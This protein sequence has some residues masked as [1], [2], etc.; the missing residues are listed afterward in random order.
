MNSNLKECICDKT[1]HIN[2]YIFYF[3]YPQEKGYESWYWHDFDLKLVQYLYKKFPLSAIGHL[4]QDASF[5]RLFNKASLSSMIEIP[6]KKFFITRLNDE[7]KDKFLLKKDFGHEWFI[8]Y[9]KRDKNDILINEIEMFG[10][11]DIEKLLYK[12]TI[13]ES[14]LVKKFINGTIH[15]CLKPSV[16]FDLF[17]KEEKIFIKERD[18]DFLEFD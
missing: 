1:E 18:I 3:D 12:S 10:V 13:I 15:L 4:K 2:K 14:I 11:D 9:L 8:F 5:C 17:L 6:K 16:S 7:N